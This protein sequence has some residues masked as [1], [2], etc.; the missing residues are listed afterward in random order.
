M[1]EK[2]R[3]KPVNPPIFFK[4]TKIPFLSIFH[5]ESTAKLFF[6]PSGLEPLLVVGMGP[7]IR[8][9]RR[10]HHAETGL[11]IGAAHRWNGTWNG[12]SVVMWVNFPDSMGIS[13]DLTMFAYW[14]FFWQMMSSQKSKQTGWDTLHTAKPTL[15]TVLTNRRIKASKI[16]DRTVK[17]EVSYRY[18]MIL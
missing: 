16:G 11:S 5:C 14:C 9:L 1:L 6:A 15:V 2:R 17:G 4:L 13:V 18:Y 8:A 3:V 12:R 10:F 7:A